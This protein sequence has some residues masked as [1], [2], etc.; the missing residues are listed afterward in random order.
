M[1]YTPFDTNSQPLCFERKSIVNQKYYNLENPQ[2]QNKLH[3]LNNYFLANEDINSS[4]NNYNNDFFHIIRFQGDDVSKCKAEAT[5]HLANFFLVNDLHFTNNND[6]LP[7]YNC[8]VPKSNI[9]YYE[10]PNYQEKE[11]VFSLIISPINLFI[12]N[13][14]IK[15]NKIENITDEN[16]LKKS[17]HKCVKY[18]PDYRPD[19]HLNYFGK[20]NNFVLYKN[21][22][23]E[24]TLTSVNN[25][26]LED[27]DI[28]YDN[29]FIKKNY[30]FRKCDKK[31]GETTGISSESVTGNNFNSFFYELDC[32]Y[33]HTEDTSLN[34][35]IKDT[36]PFFKEIQNTIGIINNDVTNVIDIYTKY[37][38]NVELIENK[39]IQQKNKL[40]KIK[41]NNN[42]NNANLFDS[43]YL[44]KIK[45]M[46]II[47]LS[48]IA[49]LAIII[50]V[51]KK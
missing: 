45:L 30:S 43:K 13:F 26:R 17:L 39:L 51:K 16:T 33:C 8:L 20:D 38:N 18:K 35:Y 22:I 44:K 36:E 34:D 48:I 47:T 14:L 1:D 49:I 6:D 42:G 41:K 27:Y 12:E 50:A 25:N 3:N 19:S 15:S 5:K 46:E 10:E 2:D 31:E 28:S 23:N 21:T 11:S 7:K 37:L 4:D 29:Y 40:N 24:E 32:E 9:K